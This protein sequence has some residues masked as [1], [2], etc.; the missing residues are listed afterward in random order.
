MI[1]EKEHVNIKRRVL[2]LHCWANFIIQIFHF[3]ILNLFK[4]PNFNFLSGFASVLLNY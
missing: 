2:V 3:K 1:V 4:Y